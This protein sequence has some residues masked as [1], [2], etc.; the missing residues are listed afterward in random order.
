SPPTAA[1]SS[2]APPNARWMPSTR[3]SAEPIDASPPTGVTPPQYDFNHNAPPAGDLPPAN[4]TA[5]SNTAPS[6]TVPSNTVPSNT[7]PYS[8]PYGSAPPRY[9]MD[10][11]Q[12]DPQGGAESNVPGPQDTPDAA[13]SETTPSGETSDSPADPS[14]QPGSSMPATSTPVAEPAVVAPAA[15]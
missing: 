5:P 15:S 2:T 13:A 1:S 8:P 11:F 10:Q 9:Q 14:A 7:A 3:R 6:N 4:A 12:P